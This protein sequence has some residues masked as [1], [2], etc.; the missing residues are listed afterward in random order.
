MSILTVIKD[1]FSNLPYS[2]GNKIAALPIELKPGFGFKYSKRKKEISNFEVLEQNKKEMFIFERVKNIAVFANRNIPFY[3]DIY[4]ENNVNPEKFTNFNDISNL[5]IIRKSDLQSVDIEYRSSFQKSRYI[6]N[7]GGSSGNP[8]SFY[9]ESNSIPHEWAHMHTIWERIGFN[10]NSLRLVFSGRSNVKDII[11]YDSVRH[12][13]NIDIYAGWNVIADKLF[14]MMKY[15][16]PKYLHGYPSAIFDFIFWLDENSHPLLE[17]FRDKIE[18]IFLG[19]EYPSPYLRDEVEKLINAKTISWYG[20]TERAI[21]AGEINKGQYC[22]FL[23]YG[24]S[25]AKNNNGKYHLISTSYYNLASPF[26]RYDTEDL[27]VP[28][29]NNNLLEYFHIESGRNGEY[30]LDKIGIKVYLTALIFGRHHALFDYCSNIQVK[31]TI[32]G[33]ASIFYVKRNSNIKIQAFELFDTSNIDI[34]FKF[35]E[36]SEPLKTNSGK[37][38]LLIK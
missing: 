33:F 34:E 13:L 6:V 19:S 38:Q 23:S 8:L 16:N 4:R 27:I 15:Y 37:V 26:I 7:T 18:S 20:H 9:I 32:K 3:R 14:L 35:I 22:P 17:I 24:F 29:Y 25:E 30:I 11:Q 36:T 10:P 1:N 12:Q 21:L 31:Q 28:K 2:I 5:P